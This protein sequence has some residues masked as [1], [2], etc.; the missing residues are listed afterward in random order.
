MNLKDFNVINILLMHLYV[1]YWIV[2]C[3][4]YAQAIVCILIQTFK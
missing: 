1:N 2:M 3:Y 4:S